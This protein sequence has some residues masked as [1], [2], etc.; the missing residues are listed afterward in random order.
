MSAWSRGG[1]DN[2]TGQRRG[3][4]RAALGVPYRRKGATGY[5]ATEDLEIGTSTGDD[6]RG[7]TCCTSR[8]RGEDRVLAIDLDPPG[9]SVELVSCRADA[10]SR[11]W[12]RRLSWRYAF[13]AGVR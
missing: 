4:T 12:R 2:R 13:P 9:N 5:A 7:T 11:E 3:S 1:H 6:K 8:R 10:A